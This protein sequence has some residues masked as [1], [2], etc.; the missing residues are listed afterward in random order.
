MTWTH[1]NISNTIITIR[2]NEIMTKSTGCEILLEDIPI[3]GITHFFKDGT[4]IL[5]G[6][7]FKKKL[8]MCCCIL[9]E[10]T[11]ELRK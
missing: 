3:S 8:A 10:C 9:N 5:D 2:K 1:Y 6:S 4:P 11:T 7:K